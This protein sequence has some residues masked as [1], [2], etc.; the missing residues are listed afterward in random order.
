MYV[1]L[2]DQ[3]IHVFHYLFSIVLI[4]IILPRFF[5]NSLYK[6]NLEKIFSD[7][8]KMSCILI[9]LGYI[10]LIFQL[11]EIISVVFLLFFVGIRIIKFRRKSTTL[12]E[13]IS[14]LEALMYDFFDGKFKLREAINLYFKTRI[15]SVKIFFKDKFLNPKNMV[16]SISIIFIL[17]FAI[18][19]RVY[20]VL[21]LASP[22]YGNRYTTIKWIKDIRGNEMFNDG[23]YPQ[24]LHIFWATIQE[25]TRIDVLYMAKYTGPLIQILIILGIYF[26]I[27]RLTRNLVS[28]IVGMIIY[29]MLGGYID[30]DFWKWQVEADSGTFAH[31]FMLPVLYFLILYLRDFD[32][33]ALYTLFSGMTVI[34]FI[35]P[36]S[37]LYLVIGVCLI[38][39][40][41]YIAKWKKDGSSISRV[42]LLSLFAFILSIIPFI[43]GL[44][45]G[46][47]F[48]ISF[49]QMFQ[50]EHISTY[51]LSSTPT[52]LPL[53]VSILIG[54]SWNVILK[55]ILRIPY[56][57]FIERALLI[58][59]IV[60]AMF[61]TVLKP[62]EPI[63]IDWDSSVDQYIGISKDFSPRT[64]MI[65]SK[66]TFS[67]IVQGK[68]YHMNFQELVNNY[69]P[70]EKNLTLINAS[71]PNLNIAPHVFI[72]I[73]KEF[74]DENFNQSKYAQLT[75]LY[76]T[77]RRDREAFMSWKD[78]YESENGEIEIYYEDVHLVIYY[79]ERIQD[80]DEIQ[81][82]IWGEQTK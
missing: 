67:S 2:N 14:Q 40:V 48:H 44:F 79:L 12:E 59:V 47:G 20:N 49:V 29:A 25:F 52:L 72:Y 53:I 61:F 26:V 81:T 30:S 36:T 37:Y 42:L 13:S 27:S 4:L 51:M 3:F 8:I 32:M 46:R 57:A 76:E 64:W 41:F 35:H 28:G 5:L 55:Y 24:G 7:A 23:I 45:L 66:E 38:S 22:S 10:L 60:S 80:L 18:Y 16:T 75:S 78:K 77:W 15:Q 33:N 31:I 74:R 50:S 43:I 73:E 63:K 70:S 39:I 54:F 68:G 17:M 71:E 58:I 1:H 82:D 62:I 21:Y 11:F 6:D 56:Q 19:I 9:S 69:T 34:A 65:V